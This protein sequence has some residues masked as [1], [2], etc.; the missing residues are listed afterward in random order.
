LVSSP[1]GGPGDHLTVFHVQTGTLLLDESYDQ[2]H[3]GLFPLSIT[4]N[5]AQLREWGDRSKF[6]AR[7]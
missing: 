6:P 7:Q 3:V 4:R 1:A 5:R 2:S